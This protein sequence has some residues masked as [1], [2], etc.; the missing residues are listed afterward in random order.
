[1]A[2]GSIVALSAFGQ[3]YPTSQYPVLQSVPAGNGM[4]LYPEPSVPQTT[5]PTTTEENFAVTQPMASEPMPSDPMQ[6]DRSMS[7]DSWG[8]PEFSTP[9]NFVAPMSNASMPNAPMPAM[10]TSSPTRYPMSELNGSANSDRYASMSQQP[11]AGP[12]FGNQSYRGDAIIAEPN[13]TASTGDSIF[14]SVKQAGSGTKSLPS[15]QNP[16]AENVGNSNVDLASPYTQPAPTAQ[17]IAGSFEQDFSPA[18]SVPGTTSWATP[19]L[20]SATTG[21]SDPSFPANVNSTWPNVPYPTTIGPTN[22]ASDDGVIVQQPAN[23]SSGSWLYPE[24][25]KFQSVPNIEPPYAF[26]QE[27][28]VAQPNLPTFDPQI[29]HRQPWPTVRPK[30]YVNDNTSFGFEEK[31]EDF[32]PFSEILATG[33]YFGSVTAAYLKPHFQG[34]TAITSGG[35]GVNEATAFDFDHR[36]NASSRF[37]FESKYGPGVEVNLFNLNFDSELSQF[38]SNGIQSGQ[39]SVTVAGVGNPIFAIADDAGETLI[40]QS[41]IEVDSL[42][43]SV[44]K[45]LQFKRARLLGNFGFQYVSVGQQ[46]LADVTAGGVVVDRLRSTTDIRAFGPRAILEYYRPV[47]HTPLEFVTSFGGSLLFGERDQFV[48]STTAGTFNRSGSEE[49]ITVAEYLAGLQYKKMTGEDRAW[50]ARV[51]FVHQSWLG[52]GTATFPQGDFG[53]NGIT[54]GVGLNR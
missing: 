32:P 50:F 22:Y 43:L 14:K 21:T 12:G 38:D 44:Y 26:P 52:G 27:S 6:Q 30:S 24:S 18:P 25:P 48:N 20:N 34:N 45:A 19:P 49:F 33:K 9:Q 37:G 46:L 42:S 28:Y 40:S 11:I 10:Q 15:F 51:A 35:G 16:V 36:T 53:F 7:P 47:G 29:G 13:R 17:T 41:S 39:T 8:S 5:W 1:M 23:A 4:S 54:L 3:D 31:K 2:A